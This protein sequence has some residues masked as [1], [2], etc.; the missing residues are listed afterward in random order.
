MDKNKVGF[1]VNPIAGIG[2]KVGFKGSDGK[3]ILKKAQVLGAKSSCPKRAAEALKKL[4][5]IKDNIE[6]ITYPYEMGEIEAEKCGFQPTVIGSIKRGA[7]TAIDTKNAAEKMTKTNVNIILFAGG[8]GTARDIFSAIGDKVPVVGI[9]AGVKIHS[10]VFTTSPE[11]AGDLIVR[12]LSHSGRMRIR[13]AEVMDIDEQ[14]FRENRVSARLYG[15][16]RVPYEKRSV[17]GVKVGSAA[18]E[19]K[20][21][22]A[23]AADVI[24]NMEKDCIY[25]IGPGTTTG[26]I[27][28]KLGL[29]HTLLGV[30]AICNRNLIGLDLNE[31]QLLELVHGRK[32]RIVVTVIGGQG[33]IFGRGN[34]Q[35][36]AEVI[37][38]VGVKNVMVLATAS[39]IHSL[40][41]NVLLVDTDDKDVNRMLSGYSKVI[42]GINQRVMMQVSV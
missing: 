12:Y 31:K 17:Q 28:E 3:E 37:K 9:P 42:T 5:H 29:R 32:A 27:M 36:S 22:D 15:Y 20:S 40:L 41:N 35:I 26:A 23:I 39:K 2:G 13:E 10:A 21:A 19:K 25:I 7:T 11:R 4:E 34:Q 8:D 16:L 1:I 33:F 38:R 18:D 6:V 24:N 30:D 14:A